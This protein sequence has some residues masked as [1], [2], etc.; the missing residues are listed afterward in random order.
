VAHTVGLPLRRALE[1]PGLARRAAQL[2]LVAVFGAWVF[3]SGSDLYF[4][5]ELRGKQPV[6][7]LGSQ[8]A[9]APGHPFEEFDRIV[10]ALRKPADKTRLPAISHWAPELLAWVRDRYEFHRRTKDFILLLPRSSQESSG[11]R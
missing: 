11:E 5:P 4:R 3:L 6:T 9:I 1:R 8:T 10:I 7:T 2:G